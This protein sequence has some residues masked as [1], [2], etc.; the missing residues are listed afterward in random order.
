M[1][2]EIFALA[3]LALCA[4]AKGGFAADVASPDAAPLRFAAAPVESGVAATVNNEKIMLVEINRQLEAI[5]IANP[6]LNTTLPAAKEA[7][8]SFRQKILD[9]L[10][11]WR[12]LV[13]EAR[14]RKIVPSEAAVT[15][16]F[17][18][19][20]EGANAAD[21]DKMLAKQGRTRAGMRQFLA[22]DLAVTELAKRLTA[23]ITVSD[24]EIKTFY[25]EHLDNW[26]IPESIQAHHILLAFGNKPGVQPTAGQ[27]A[28]AKKRA[29]DVLKELNKRGADFEIIAAKNSD[30]ASKQVGGNI[31]VSLDQWET[32]IADV[33]RA[34]KIGAL[35]G[36][37]EVASGYSIVRVD[38]R[39]PAGSQSL[40][41]MR[42]YIKSVLLEQK[43]KAKLDQ[44][45]Q[46]LRSVAKITKFI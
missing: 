3:A 9:N 20:R 36:P 37:I 42:A 46:A 12:L 40:V 18:R 11:E 27:K 38:A 39:M 29:L 30:S 25:N 13:Q 33:V 22:D 26:K 14:R 15:E 16:S 41:Q 2:K 43:N 31:E 10:I 7:M 23:D 6:E 45:I 32:G 5:R 17:D 35:V 4:Q 21:F 1:K 28:A 19:L 44:Q 8:E 34:A 24:D